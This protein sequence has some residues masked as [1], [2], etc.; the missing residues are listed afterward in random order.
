[1]SWKKAVDGRAG[2]KRGLVFKLKRRR[3][4]MIL[5]TQQED[6]GAMGADGTEVGNDADGDD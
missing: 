5:L 6:V 3:V 2:V 4:R 1:M